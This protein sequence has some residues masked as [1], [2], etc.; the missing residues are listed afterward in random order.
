MDVEEAG[1]RDRQ[2]AEGPGSSST[3]RRSSTELAALGYDVKSHSTSLE[4]DQATSAVQ[5]IVDKRKPQR[6]PAARDRQGLRRPP[7][8]PRARGAD[9]NGHHP[10][11]AAPPHEPEPAVATHAP[12]PAPMAEAPAAAEP[13][14]APAPEP[15][16]AAPA[17]EPVDA[18]VAP[19]EPPAAVPVPPAEA[20]PEATPHV[21]PAAPP[22]AA[23]RSGPARRGPPGADQLQPPPQG[24]RA[25]SPPALRPG[26]A[27][28]GSAR[29]SPRAPR[30]GPSGLAAAAPRRP[31]PSPAPGPPG[32]VRVAVRA[33]RALT[34][35]RDHRRIRARSGR[36]PPRRSSSPV[37][38]IPVRRVTP[39]STAHKNI[40]RRAGPQ[41]HRRGPGVQGGP[42]SPR[43]RPR[44]RRRHQEQG[45][46]RSAARSAPPRRTAPSSSRQMDALASGAGSMI[47]IRGKKKKPT[48]KGR[49]TQITEMAED[50]KV[51]KHRGD[52]HASP[53]SPSAWA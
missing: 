29:G 43:P 40:P 39:S 37:P 45:R 7:P 20:A 2:G 6:G 12:E 15:V 51:I 32:R 1:S 14:A 19:P 44:V 53:S 38:L 42:R 4:D 48:K 31:G 23:R 36:P 49:K 25:G 35:R 5:R 52:H 10:E 47:P 18:P 26:S 24:A 34:R 27:P 13:P 30:A 33:A 16:A 21:S 17:A 3:T 50:K 22:P 46:A 41:G 11:P 8:G 9:T 28:A